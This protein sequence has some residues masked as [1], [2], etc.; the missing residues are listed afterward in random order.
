MYTSITVFHCPLFNCSL[1]RLAISSSFLNLF[2]MPVAL[3][4]CFL[5]T[6]A[7]MPSGGLRSSGFRLGA[8]GILHTFKFL[9]TLLINPV[10]FKS[11]NVEHKQRK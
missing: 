5:P 9:A 7:D 6:H 8:G 4:F 10:N 11:S 2:S 3:D 1:H